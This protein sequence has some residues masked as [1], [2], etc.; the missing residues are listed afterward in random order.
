MPDSF[1]EPER[2]DK[3]LVKRQNREGEAVRKQIRAISLAKCPRNDQHQERDI[4]I[5]S[6]LHIQR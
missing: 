2:G 1:I 6:F 5:S 4:L 3:E